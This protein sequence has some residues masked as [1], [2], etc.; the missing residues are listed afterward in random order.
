MAPRQQVG[1][2][3]GLRIEAGGGR[4]RRGC[5]ALVLA[6]LLLAATPAG[7]QPA[8]T[9]ADV[10][11]VYEG[12]WHNLTFDS[13]GGARIRIEADGGTG[14][15]GVDLDGNVFG[16][17]DPPEVVFTGTLGSGSIQKD[18]DSVFGDVDCTGDPSSFTCTGNMIN[19]S[20]LSGSITG[21]VSGGTINTTYQL[22]LVGMQV[23]NGTL[24]ATKLPEPGATAA[25]AVA[26]AALGALRRPARR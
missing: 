6:P 7:A 20:V 3:S 11:G 18:D 22:E 26:L 21:G 15:L 24:V 8:P 2:G 13:Q 1:T 14:T 19:D 16:M 5:T 17:F 9:L 10:A 4:R 12:T 23:A 25:G